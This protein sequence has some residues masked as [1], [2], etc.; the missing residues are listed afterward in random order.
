VKRYVM[1]CEGGFDE[2][3]K[4]AT[5]VMRYAD[6][7]TVAVIDSTR[8]GST[9]ADA[10]P[11]MTDRVP[12]VATLA[13]TLAQAPTT[14]LIGVAPAGGK[15]PPSFRAVVKEA[16]EHGLDVEN[17]LHDFL[18]G[19]P[20]L[21]LAAAAGG[22]EIRDLRRA[23]ADLNVPTLANLSVAAR[24]V[25]AVGSDCGLGKMTVC[26]ELDRAARRRG[27]ASQFVPTGQT[28]IAIAGWGIAVDEVVSDFIAGAAERLVLEGHSRAGDGALLWIEGQGSINHPFYSGVTTGL[29]HGSAPHALL[30]VH[31]PGREL[32]DG[33]PRLPIPPIEELIADNERVTQFV[34][35]AS[36]VALALKTNRLDES[37]ARSAIAEYTERT[38]LVT[39]DPVRF[40]SGRL[41]DAVIAATGG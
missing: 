2:D 9:A 37:A 12:I 26:L 20:E 39:D 29:I 31:E 8:A 35:P 18:A 5:G 13:E 36:V 6:A 3:A 28:G 14:L 11:G 21:A 16:L 17:G 23:P 22:S 15:L 33:D 4:T 1:L 32:I 27:L 34:R 30:F 41:L 40:G 25:L 38:G 10:V 19:D 24:T 7:V